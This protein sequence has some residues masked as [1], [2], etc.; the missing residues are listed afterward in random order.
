MDGIFQQRTVSLDGVEHRYQLWLPQ[1]FCGHGAWP[2]VLFLHGAGEKGDDGERQTTVGLGPALRAQPERWPLLAVFP[3]CRE[4]QAWRGPMLTQAVAALDDA[5]LA[6]GADAGR[7]YLTGISMGGYGS[8][9]LALDNPG[10]FAALVPIC[11]GLDASPGV[12][13]RA[14][15]R[16]ERKLAAEGEPELPAGS[17]GP[18]PHAAAALTLAALP[19]WIFHGSADDTIPVSESR[20]MYQAMLHAGADV[21]YTEYPGVGHDAWTRAYAEAELPQWLLSR[22]R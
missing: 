6:T 12:L 14:L 9:R 15:A 3:Q 11:G 17:D 7:Q 22:K 8:W 4:R 5:I 18:D 1:G 2:I 21:R 13:D 20:V 10:R 19:T 16:L